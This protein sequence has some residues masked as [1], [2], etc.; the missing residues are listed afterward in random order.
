MPPDDKSVA[1]TDG[2]SRLTVEALDA[3]E[4]GHWDKVQAC[5]HERATWLGHN[6]VS[7]NLAQALLAMDARVT[8]VAQAARAAIEQ[9]LAQTQ[10]AHRQWKTLSATLGDTGSVGHQLDRLT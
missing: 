1:W 7:S 10:T 6:Y 9:E 3:A 4:R 5:Y 8:A 2:I